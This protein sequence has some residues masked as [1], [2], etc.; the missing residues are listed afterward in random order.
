MSVPHLHDIYNVLEY[1][2]LFRGLEFLSY[3]VIFLY[4]WFLHIHSF[5][6]CT[7]YGIFPCSESPAQCFT[8]K[9]LLIGKDMVITLKLSYTS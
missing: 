3:F 4:P 9:S 5:H 7:S 2:L 6:T 8:N 1:D